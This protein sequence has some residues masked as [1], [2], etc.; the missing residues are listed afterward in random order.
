M[1]NFGF[2][3]LVGGILGFLYCSSQLQG[4]EPLPADVPIADYFRNV[5]GRMELGRFASIGAALI[6]V[7]FAMFPQGR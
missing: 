1:R 3:L 6:G 5:A 4:L 2:A 7:L